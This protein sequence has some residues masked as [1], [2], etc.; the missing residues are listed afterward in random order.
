MTD[1]ES[2]PMFWNLQENV[3]TDADIGEMVDFIRTAKRFTQSGE[4]RKFEAAYAE[5]QGCRHAVFVNSG[6]SAN[7]ILLAAAKERRGWP[8]QSEVIVPAVTWTTTVTPVIQLG[9]KPVFVDANLSDLSFDY[10]MLARAI[11]PRTR[12]I[13]LAHLLGFPADLE[14][15]RVIIGDRPID[16]LEDTCESQ[17]AHIGGE[18]LGSIG[19]GRHF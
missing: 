18:K 10:E 9:L 2:G 12:A 6:S 4:V 16:I 15:I 3:L 7:L 14:R 11:T 5:W 19:L 8:A 17:G 1:D 13:F